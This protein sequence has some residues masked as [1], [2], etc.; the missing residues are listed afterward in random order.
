MHTSAVCVVIT[1]ADFKILELK[2]FKLDCAYHF[3]CKHESTS[4]SCK[5]LTCINFEVVDLYR[6]K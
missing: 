3:G 2:K 6:F 5:Y 1:F 4:L